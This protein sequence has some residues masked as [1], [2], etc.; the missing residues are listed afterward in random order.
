MIQIKKTAMN[1]LCVFIKPPSIDELE[2]RLRGRKTE[3]EDSIQKRLSVAAKEI[4]YGDT[5]GNF[6]L[7]IVNDNV[8]AAGEKLKTFMDPHVNKLL[9]ERKK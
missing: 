2:K 3:T 1:P 8:E 6:D 7:I 4:A 5:P 9:E